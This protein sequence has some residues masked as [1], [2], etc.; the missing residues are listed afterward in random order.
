M[1]LLAAE[2]M[3]GDAHKE[4]ALLTVYV[5]LENVWKWISITGKNELPSYEVRQMDLHLV[6]LSG[7]VLSFSWG[8]CP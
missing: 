1:D 5:Y 3:Q 6:F 2:E 4:K 8:I 7:H